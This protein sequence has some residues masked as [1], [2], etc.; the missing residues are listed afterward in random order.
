MSREE[1]NGLRKHIWGA[2][3]TV[4]GVVIVQL[5]AAI[6]WAGKIDARVEGVER[7]LERVEARVLRVEAG[8]PRATMR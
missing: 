7:G 4:A 1:S 2:A 8:E 3:G 6:F 5:V